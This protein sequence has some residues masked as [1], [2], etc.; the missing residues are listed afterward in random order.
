MK[1]TDKYSVL[2][3]SY[4][5]AAVKNTDFPKIPDFGPFSPYP[6]KG[7][8]LVISR[9]SVFSHIFRFW[10]FSRFWVFRHFRPR[11]EIWWF[12][13]FYE[14]GDF[15]D[16][17]DIPRNMKSGDFYEIWKNAIFPHLYILHIL[18]FFMKFGKI[19]YFYYIWYC[20]NCM[21]SNISNL[22]KKDIWENF[23]MLWKKN[24]RDF[25]KGVG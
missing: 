8:F 10:W 16:S 9:K 11:M 6:E 19:G 20:G 21:F 17:G 15:R 2:C 14:I 22:V 18:M 7:P 25:P 5:V 3:V 4:I 12:F 13:T 23:W 1:S 24:S